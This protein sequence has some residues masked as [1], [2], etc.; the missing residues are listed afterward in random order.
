MATFLYD[1]FRRSLFGYASAVSIVIFSL[2][3][4]IALGY[5]RI[6]MRRDLQGTGLVG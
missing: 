5:Q 2:S 4:V 3:L 1:Q 6:V